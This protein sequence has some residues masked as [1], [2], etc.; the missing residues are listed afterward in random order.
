MKEL[1]NQ[2][3]FKD[4]H[5][6]FNRKTVSVNTGLTVV[7]QYFNCL[8]VA[9]TNTSKTTKNMQQYH[10]CVLVCER[11]FANLFVILPIYNDTLRLM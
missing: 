2:F 4:I 8:A 7:A 3:L 5:L 9:A 10:V 6:S 11:D 1:D